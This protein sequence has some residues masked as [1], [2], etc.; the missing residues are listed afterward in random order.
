MALPNKETVVTWGQIKH[1]Q[2]F[3]LTDTFK[4]FLSP[5]KPRNDVF[6]WYVGHDP[7]NSLD[8]HAFMNRV[9]A[10]EQNEG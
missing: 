2:K 10:S 3:V 8:D 5:T 6:Y 7:Y 4:R 9:L 1:I